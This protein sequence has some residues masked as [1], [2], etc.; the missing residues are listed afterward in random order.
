ME[1]M[2]TILTHKNTRLILVGAAIIYAFLRISSCTTATITKIYDDARAAPI[3]LTVHEKSKIV[4]EKNR[5]RYATRT[6][7]GKTAIKDTYV[8]PEGKV[9]VI[10]PKV[11]DLVV[12]VKNKGLTFSPGVGG[13]LVGTTGG[14]FVF[15][16]FAYYKRL[17]VVG[18]IGLNQHEEIVPFV[19]TTYHVK[20][21]SFLLFGVGTEAKIVVGVAVNF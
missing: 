18:G 14:G 7:D 10:E 8:P 11:G 15:T 17:G 13:G 4:V 9:T 19:G 12:K 5:V 21:N 16:K 3:V 2:W 6:S 1:K 20:A